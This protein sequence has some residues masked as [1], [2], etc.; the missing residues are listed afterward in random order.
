MSKPKQRF[1]EIVSQH[2]YSIQRKINDEEE[3][4]VL[5]CQF[6]PGGKS[7]GRFCQTNRRA[8]IGQIK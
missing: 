3:E 8:G 1:R 2:H 7:F 6:K 5:A 4:I